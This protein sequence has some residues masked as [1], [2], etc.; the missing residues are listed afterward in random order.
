MAR[1]LDCFSTVTFALVTGLGLPAYAQQ[2]PNSPP[3][4]ATYQAHRVQ[5]F[6]GVVAA[7]HQLASEAGAAVL[8][9]GGNAAD[10]GAAA[11]LTLGLVHPFASGLGGG[12]FCLYREVEKGKTTVLDYRERAPSA[13]HRDMYVVDGEVQPGLARHGGLAVGVPGEAAGIWSLHGRFG[14]LA[15]DQVVTPALGLAEQGFP[16]GATLAR[17]LQTLAPT[18]EE[19][20]ALKAVFSDA[21]GNLLQEGDLM[22]RED[23]ARALTLLRDEGVAPFYSGEVAEAMV[24]SVQ[25][26]GGILTMEDLR[27]YQVSLRE[28][29]TGTYQDFELISMPPPSSGGVALI[30]AFN[31]LEGFELESQA[32]DAP[33]IHLVVE[34]IKH[35]FADR[36]T[37]LGDTDFVDVPVERLI[38]KAYAAELRET[39]ELNSVKPTEA[40][41]STAP[42]EDPPGT[43]HLSVVD[44]AGNMLACTTTINTRF[45]SM[46]YDPSFGLILNNEMADFNIAPGQPNLYGLMGNEQ[47]AVAPDKRPLSSMSPTLVLR[48]GEPYMSVGGSGGPT[49]ITGTYFTL[50][51]TLIFGMDVLEAVAQP[52]LHHQWLP[53]QLFIEFDNLRFAPGLDERGHQLQTRRAY[54]AIQAIQRQ[55]DGS[56]AAVSDPRKGGIPAA[57]P[58]KAPTSPQQPAAE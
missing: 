53:E 7:D 48:R 18:L 13:A 17:H 39:I 45:G 4:S 43:S 15:W 8:A 26:A 12:G 16:V 47:N 58:V 32:W 27:R 6:D 24:E 28:P 36:A 38:S 23:L 33:A 49:I 50:V 35:A 3:E 22:V 1:T 9:A 31:I 19:W 46:V 21:E 29:L 14:Q 5:S 55:P 20:P 11:M 52:R 30:E 2:A 44:A 56:W 40:Y 37:Y 51:G 57:P 42:S 10:A 34:A 25:A 41:G 54:N